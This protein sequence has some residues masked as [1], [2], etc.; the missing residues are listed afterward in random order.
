LRF[1]IPYMEHLSEVKTLLSTPRKVV[2]TMH[3]HPDADALGSS[4]AW[5]HYLLKLG[6]TCS[7]IAPDE[8]PDFLKWMEGHETVWVYE[9]QTTVVQE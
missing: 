2:I 5:Y 4:L 3:A 7:V 9:E 8:Y 1:L 6:H